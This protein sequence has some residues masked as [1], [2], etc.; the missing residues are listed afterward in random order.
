MFGESSHN[1]VHGSPVAPISRAPPR[2]TGVHFGR[3]KSSLTDAR[4]ESNRVCFADA[5]SKV[6]HVR[7]LPI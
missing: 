6:S 2:V 3:R 4:P 7:R 5:G 1:S